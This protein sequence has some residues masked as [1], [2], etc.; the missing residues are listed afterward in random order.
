MGYNNENSLLTGSLLMECPDDYTVLDIETTGLNPVTDC[1]T[2]ISAIRYRKNRKVDEFV[3]L[4]KPDCAIPEFITRLTGIDNA[5][6]ANAPAIEDVIGSF[7]E[8]IGED[9]LMGYNVTFDLGFL[10]NK[11]A[12]I[13]AS[14]INNDYVDVMKLA[15]DKLPF[16]GRAKQ[17]VVAKYFSIPTG[18]AHRAAIDCE[19]CNG[20]YQKLKQ[21]YIAGYEL[22]QKQRELVV[23]EDAGQ[24]FSDKHI[25]FLGVPEGFYLKNL[26]QVVSELGAVLDNEA[27]SATSMAIVG[28]GDTSICNDKELAHIVSMKEQGAHVSLLKDNVFVKALLSKGWV[29]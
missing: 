13:F 4:V 15:Q 19:I 12:S 22:P 14:T 29:K 27:D 16:L 20:C 2:E 10:A 26:Q 8:F 3:T 17:T 11:L 18:G 1:I 5:A 28:T 23:A 24:P 6:V 21:L 7:K 9:V 25:A